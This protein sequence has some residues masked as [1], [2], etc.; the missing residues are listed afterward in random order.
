MISCSCR[1]SL[2]CS[3]ISSKNDGGGDKC[4]NERHLVNMEKNENS[5]E[6][7]LVCFGQGLHCYIMQLL[8]M[9]YFV[10]TSL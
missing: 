1:T 2:C 7:S 10:H 4:L 8:Q 6:D 5:A 3:D 9:S